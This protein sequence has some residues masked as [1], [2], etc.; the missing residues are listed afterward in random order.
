[1]SV[2]QHSSG[3]QSGWIGWIYFAGAMLILD[4]F[5]QAVAGLVAILKHSVYVT[6]SSSLVLLDY[7]QWG[8][9]HL[10]VGIFLVLAGIAIFSGR[11]WGRIVGVIAAILS[12]LA[13]FAFFQAYPLWSLIVIVIDVLVIYA[14]TVHGGE[15]EAE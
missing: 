6:T 9:I 5:F 14:I 2:A 11:L 8:W 1:M 13:S 7:T 4:G 10:I 15:V 3:Y 12:A